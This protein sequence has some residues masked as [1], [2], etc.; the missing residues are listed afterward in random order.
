MGEWAPGPNAHWGKTMARAKVL[1]EHG[2]GAPRK[3][4]PDEDKQ[5]QLFRRVEKSDNTP[6]YGYGDFTDVSWQPG[7]R[8]FASSLEAAQVRFRKL[9]SHVRF[10]GRFP[11][12]QVRE[13]KK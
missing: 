5:F 13:V 7:Q 3:L 2:E 10:S 1:R 4:R 11:G 9:G 6:E 8:V 12:Y